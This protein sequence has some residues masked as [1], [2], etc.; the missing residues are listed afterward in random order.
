[1]DLFQRAAGAFRRRVV[2]PLMHATPIE[3]DPRTGVR[4]RRYRDYRHYVRHQAAK[5]RRNFETLSEH[6]IAY[7]EIVVERYAA[8]PLH[9][10]NV[11]CLGARLGGEVRAF[12]RLGALALGVDLEPGPNNRHVLPGDVHALQFADGVFDYAFTNIL[13]HVLDLEAFTTEVL[14][15]LRREG[16]LIAELSSGPIKNY[17]VNDLTDGRV[18]AFIGQR[19]RLLNQTPI[20]NKTSY[21]DWRG[22]QA[23]YAKRD[24]PL[25]WAHGEERSRPLCDGAGD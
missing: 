4:A 18:Q 20:V 5:L 23:T 24:C 1:M 16:L 8:L 6:D 13:D 9:G 21:T 19:M 2:A 25:Q 17:E 15:V 11:L 3:V 14:R 10:R 7:E 22:V 12:R